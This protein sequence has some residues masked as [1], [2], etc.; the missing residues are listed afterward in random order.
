MN[1]LLIIFALAFVPCCGCVAPSK[2]VARSQEKAVFDAILQQSQVVQVKIDAI[3]KAVQP[4]EYETIREIIREENAG[5]IDQFAKQS[6]SPIPDKQ[7]SNPKQLPDE[8]IE[9]FEELPHPKIEPL[10]EPET[11]SFELKSYSQH[12]G[13]NGM[14]VDYQLTNAPHFVA[15]WV[16]AD[17]TYTQKMDLHTALHN[18]DLIV[19]DGI[20]RN[21]QQS[22]IVK[23]NE[24]DPESTITIYTADWCRYC[25][26]WLRVE[27]PRL[28]EKGWRII[29]IES[30]IGP[31]PRFE[32]SNRGNRYTHS[33]Y[34]SMGTLRQ[35]LGR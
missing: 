21:V 31:L 34:M 5:L 24:A 29:P 4:V 15:V 12:V 14:T 26:D 27:A 8:E 32:I 1:R 23:K 6:Q 17:M 11:I 35:L 28:R 7:L 25:K 3:A 30:S 18:G 9:E 19:V 13:I 16:I 2:Q 10:P 22:D 20:P 33:G